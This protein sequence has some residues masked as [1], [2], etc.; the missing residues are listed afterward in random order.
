MP[1]SDFKC[2][3]CNRPRN[4]C[5]TIVAAKEDVGPFICNRCIDLASKELQAGSK[6]GFETKKDEEPVKKPKEIFAH[7]DQYVIGQEKAKIDVSV[8]VYNHFKRRSAKEKPPEEVVELDKSNILLMGPSGSGKTQLARSIAK[9]LKIPFFVGDATK[10][11][12]AGYVGDDVETL[13]QG[14]IQEAGGDV[15]RAQ[16]GIIFLDEVDKIAR[17]GGRDRAGYRDVSGEGV[18]QALLKLLEGTKINVPRNNGGRSNQLSS[19]D[20]IDTTNILFI[21]AGSFAGIEAI[22]ER[23]LSKGSHLGFG[24]EVKAKKLDKTASYLSVLEDDLLEFGIIPEMMGRL[25]I[26]TTT[27]ELTEDQLVQV[28]TEPRH[29]IIKQ[30]KA[31]FEIDGIILEFEPEALKAIAREAKKRLTGARALRSIVENCV[32]TL[33]FESP[34]DKTLKRITITED[35]MNG[36]PGK[37][38][39]H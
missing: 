16:W 14:L 6:N 30:F 15:E 31:L 9:L 32:K 29:S 5:K 36:G 35:T 11:T 7:L 24:S 10:L 22:I 4:E 12:Q 39:R 23:R 13:L 21:C 38:E 34:S 3:F 25:P 8:A 37:I 27:I 20:T 28:L 19:F 18:Q 17:S 33:A 26:L 2:S 1:P